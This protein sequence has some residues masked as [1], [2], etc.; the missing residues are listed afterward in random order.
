MVKSVVGA[1]APESYG[2][3]ICAFELY[4]GIIADFNSTLPDLT[5]KE[6]MNTIIIILLICGIAYLAFFKRP[7][8]ETKAELK[9]WFNDQ[10]VTISDG[11]EKDIA[12]DK[13]GHYPHSG[14]QSFE[15]KGSITYMLLDKNGS[16][17]ELSQFSELNSSDIE[18]TRGYKQLKDKVDKLGLGIRLDEVDVDGDGVQT[19]NELDE[20][21]DDYP[22]FYTVTIFGWSA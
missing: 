1:W 11:L 7:G 5:M 18:S 3:S 17:F 8:Q 4:A 16:R 2:S 15:P 14:K 22:R 12:L 6:N 21:I 10:L 13:R 9:R 20:Y 19:W